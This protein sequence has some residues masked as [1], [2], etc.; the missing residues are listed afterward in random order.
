MKNV[1]LFFL[2]CLHFINVPAQFQWAKAEGLWAY[3]YG[4][5]IANDNAGNLYVSGKYEQNALFSGTTLSC[6]GNHDAFLAK[7][8]S[9]GILTWIRTAG[10]LNGDYSHAMACDGSNN[11]YTAGE[12]E[13][14]GTIIYFPGSS[15]TLQAVGDNDIFLAKY[16]LSG[17]LLWAKSEG[18]LLNEKAQAVTYDNSGNVYIGG[19]FTD[20]TSFN[21]NITIGYGDRDVFIAKYNSGGVFQWMKKA[22]SA[23]RDEVKSMQCDAAGNIYVCGM[24]SNGANFSG[25]IL[26]CS[27]G[28][29]ETFL[30][31][32]GPDGSLKWIKTGGGAYDDVA[33]SLTMDNKSKIYV[34]GEFNGDAV[35]GTTHLY[36]SGMADVFVNC[37][38]TLGN[39]QWTKQAGGNLVDRARG[40]G[41]DGTNIFITGQYGS[42]AGFGPYPLS[43]A[44]S[45]DIFIASL[46]N[47]GNF[48]WAT[49]VGGPADA[50]ES[51]GYESGNA[52][53]AETSGNV[54]ATG[55]MLGLG[56]FGPIA[57]SPYTR[58]DAFVTKLLIFNIG[59]SENY[60]SAGINIYPNPGNGNF[61]FNVEGLSGK[62]AEITVYDCIGQK[63]ININK[64]SSEINIDLDSYGDGVYV[65]EIKTG[66]KILGRKKIIL[67]R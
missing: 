62:K 15:T 25:Q 2:L 27:A 9:G 33:W 38:D 16:D 65:A 49:C 35:F 60:N 66:E 37:Y 64:S 44:D 17:N 3:D 48:L 30:A 41:T 18:W 40:I 58:T 46:S 61:V 34:T 22:G 10:G 1:Y 55:S 20:T 26:P 6:A 7:Y 19:F 5:G 23:G 29:F 12:I 50:Y 21:G 59:I 31:K 43:A 51:L 4:Y 56:T 11:V 53:C 13:G 14:Y 57:V 47:A 28:Y 8:N 24:F 32:Y 63:I 36:S 52:V 42:N 54:Y 39:L 45:S 67:Q